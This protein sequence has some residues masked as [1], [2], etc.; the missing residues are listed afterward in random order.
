MFDWS[1]IYFQQVLKVDIFTYGYLIFMTFMA[2]SRFLSDGIVARFGMLA[3]YIMS[4]LC[5]VIGICLAI[6][7]PVFWTAMLGF[8]LVGFGVAAVIPMSYA[9]AGA[10]KKYSPGM[11]ISI[12]ATYSITGMLLGPPLIGY[13]AH[14]FNLRIS[15]VIF[16]LCGLLLIPIT[17]LFFARQK[18]EQ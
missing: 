13:L 5:I 12:I 3:T 6:I 4:A 18:L 10:S 2:A 7:F 16:A 15:F 1:G 17:R 14:A 11:A 9:L 8:S